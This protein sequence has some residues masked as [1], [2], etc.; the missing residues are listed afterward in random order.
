MILWEKPLSNNSPWHNCLCPRVSGKAIIILRKYPRYGVTNYGVTAAIRAGK[1]PR[2]DNENAQIQNPTNLLTSSA[3]FW[4]V[5]KPF[6]EMC[7]ALGF[8]ETDRTK[9][10]D[11]SAIRM[12]FCRSSGSRNW[13]TRS[14]WSRISSF[15]RVPRIAFTW[16]STCP[17]RLLL[18][19]FSPYPWTVP[20]SSRHASCF[21]ILHHEECCGGIRASHGRK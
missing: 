16:Q 15:Q 8:L 12:T 4:Q 18:F 19:H 7:S 3:N 5:L 2:G 1:F 11:C 9:N 13:R 10:T 6:C 17:L 20:P 14:P 21:V